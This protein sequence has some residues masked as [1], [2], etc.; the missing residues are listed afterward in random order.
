MTSSIPASA[1]APA[2]TSDAWRDV[3]SWR[4]ALR[5]EMIARREALSGTERAAFNERIT[6][7]LLDSFSVPARAVVGF[8]WPFR[9]EF[10]ARFAI[11]QWRQGG[12]HAALPEVVAK[13]EALRFSLW[14]PGVAMRR[15]VYDIPVP[16]RT[17]QV[18]PDLAVVPMNAF[19]D[20]G[21]RL[22]YGGGYFDGTLQALKRRVIAIGVAYERLRVATIHPQAHDIPM[23]FVVT[24]AAV[25]RGGGEALE[26]LA[27]AACR[28][29]CAALLRER[30]LPRAR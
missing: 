8:C 23:D 19:D 28:E 12:A 2:P 18:L 11:R 3:S 5:A 21:F 29:L 10:D 24:E 26:A 1:L 22:G 30:E 25:Y 4:K 6:A 7:R 9:G 27:P 13:N 15:G 16:D 14:A 20:R 17:R